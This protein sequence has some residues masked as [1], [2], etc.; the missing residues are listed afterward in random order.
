VHE[1]ERVVK[2]HRNFIGWIYMPMIYPVLEL[3]HRLI[4]AKVNMYGVHADIFAHLPI[5]ARP[6][7]A[8]KYI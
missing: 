2:A 5:G 4:H 6:F 7:S 1:H 8:F 3:L